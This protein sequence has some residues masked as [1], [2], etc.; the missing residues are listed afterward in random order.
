MSCSTTGPEPTVYE[1]AQTLDQAGVGHLQAPYADEFIIAFETQIA[2][3]TSIE[4]TYVNK[5]TKDIIEDTCSDNTWAWGDGDSPGSRRPDPPGPRARD[6]SYYMITNLRDFYRKYEGIIL[7]AETRRNRLHLLGSYTYSESKGNTA[8]G[9]LQSYATALADF[10]PVHFFNRDG[11]LPDD[12]D[13]TG[14]R[15]TATISSRTTGRSGFDGFYES[16]GSPDGVLDL[17]E[18][19]C[20]HRSDDPYLN[21]HL[22]VLVYTGDGK[23]S[24]GTTDIFISER[25]EYETKSAWQIDLQG[26]KTWNLN[27]V[28]LTVVAHGLQHLQQRSRSDLQLRSVRR[29]RGRTD[30]D[31][32]PAPSLR[33]RV[34]HRVLIKGLPARSRPALR[35]GSFFREEVRG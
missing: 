12:R 8:N 32:V 21:E 26:S 6:C 27:K 34:P 31:L 16:A 17:C 13:A 30:L 19:H 20:W 9:A 7:Q 11:Y 24:F 1:P 14:S 23:H 2:R 4:I 3:E 5:K 18:P 10:F 29:Q 28:D 35:R 22:R 15:S 25:G 33:G